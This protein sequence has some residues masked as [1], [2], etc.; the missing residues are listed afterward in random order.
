M[1]KPIHKPPAEVK[2]ETIENELQI[3][4]QS[5]VNPDFNPFK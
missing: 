2:V 5:K 4:I 1:I 3:S